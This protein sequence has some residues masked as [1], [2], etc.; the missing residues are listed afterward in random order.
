MK[1]ILA[2]EKF[3][4]VN[5]LMIQHS[6]EWEDYVEMNAQ[7][8]GMTS[9]EWMAYYGTSLHHLDEGKK[10][11]RKQLDKAIDALAAATK[12]LTEILPLWKEA[13]DS[14]DKQ[15][16]ATYLEELRKYTEEKKAAEKLVNSH[17]EAL[18]KNAELKITEAKELRW[19]PAASGGAKYLTVMLPKKGIEARE[20]YYKPKGAYV[21]DY[22]V[23]VDVNGK[24][25]YNKV[26]KILADMD[27]G[28][29]LLESVNEAT[30][31]TKEMW[32]K[33]WNIK[34]A[35][36][37]DFEERFAKRVEAAM[38]K[39]KNEDQAEEWA[40]KNFKQLPNPAKG[41]TIEE[42]VMNEGIKSFEVDVDGDYEEIDIAEI[43]AK[44]K[45]GDY[46]NIQEV[47]DEILS[48]RGYYSDDYED[49]YILGN[50]K[51]ILKAITKQTGLK[52][53]VNENSELVDRAQELDD[54]F[55]NSRN[56]RAIRHWE[57]YTEDLF[58]EYSGDQDGGRVDVYWED[59][60]EDELQTAIDVGQDMMN[61]YKIKESV[62]NEAK[63]APWPEQL[64]KGLTHWGYKKGTHTTSL[65]TLSCRIGRNAN[66]YGGPNHAQEV[67]D[68]NMKDPMVKKFFKPKFKVRP[69]GN[70]VNDHVELIPKKGYLYSLHVGTGQFEY[71]CLAM[72]P[73]EVYIFRKFDQAYG[74]Y[75][76]FQHEEDMSTRSGVFDFKRHREEEQWKWNKLKPDSA[77][78][79]VSVGWGIMDI[80][81]EYTQLEFQFEN[82]STFKSFQLNE[83]A[84]F[85]YNLGY[86]GQRGEKPY[87]K[88]A[89]VIG[90]AVKDIEGIRDYHK[91]QARGGRTAVQDISSRILI[92]TYG[93]PDIKDDIIRALKGVD[94]NLDL[95]TIKNN[96]DASD[97]SRS[98]NDQDKDKW[99]WEIQKKEDY[100]SWERK[101][102]GK[103]KQ[104][105]EFTHDHQM[106]FIDMLAPYSTT[107]H[108]LADIQITSLEDFLQYA[109]DHVSPANLKKVTKR[110]KKEYPKLENNN[111]DMK[112]LLTLESFVNERRSNYSGDD[113]KII[114]AIRDAAKEGFIIFS[115]GREMD[116]STVEISVDFNNK[117][118]PKGQFSLMP[119]DSGDYFKVGKLKKAAPKAIQRMNDELEDSDSEY[120]VKMVGLEK[121]EVIVQVVKKKDA[122][123]DDTEGSWWDNY[124]DESKEKY[125]KKHG[126]APD[127]G[128]KK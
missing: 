69:D 79:F 14:G 66:D 58:A 116:G 110:I 67:A 73:G 105:R 78:H 114:G 97:Y 42:S 5:G 82:L 54:I 41:M 21:G 12:K 81:I 35:F 61:K 20:E 50:R 94:P 87:W 37:K 96:Y 99:E 108:Q 44:S 115:S 18:D 56:R 63:G 27:K 11:T 33:E 48:D 30:E 109:A 122:K 85:E 59:I 24:S 60:P 6:S 123:D 75:E 1:N 68:L 47:I 15:A 89:E 10:V 55:Q 4:F 40:Y 84:P 117:N 34:K 39:A 111:T 91:Q 120:A 52:E 43:Q 36:G 121:R 45:Q 124:S 3:M 126:S 72:K 80:G 88:Y 22:V 32:D 92:G 128:N 19:Q 104:D 26:A 112:N 17:I 53:S 49:A 9:E 127:V 71:F 93:Q 102:G 107:Q 101:Y 106:E 95:K 7:Q 46:I 31:V 57:E 76:Y 83:K 118:L 100:H 23:V 16:E 119:F 8:M 65:K 64:E 125:I 103:P 2:L 77:S 62:V 86:K 51:K 98:K 25:E 90:N 113:E 74:Q 29:I 28:G 38:S 13:R 70:Y